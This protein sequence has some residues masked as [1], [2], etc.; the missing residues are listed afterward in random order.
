MRDTVRRTMRRG[1]V[2]AAALLT[3]AVVGVSTDARADAERVRFLAEK[4]KSDDFRVR[5][6]AALAI[7]PWGAAAFR[8]NPPTLIGG[9]VY[10]WGR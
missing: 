7:L 9:V 2:L 5:T 3:L 4:L 10:Q 1:R 8:D 6:N